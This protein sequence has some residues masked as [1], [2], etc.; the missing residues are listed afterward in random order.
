[1]I[2]VI[3]SILRRFLIPHI[4]DGAYTWTIEASFKKQN[5][6]VSGH[7]HLLLELI[8]GIVGA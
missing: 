2:S 6:A 4:K 1:M 3:K 5:S 7:S 8:D